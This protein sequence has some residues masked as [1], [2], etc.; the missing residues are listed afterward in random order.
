MDNT[1]LYLLDDKG[2][3]VPPGS[4]G[5]LYVAG[6]NLA[7]GYVKGRDAHR[8]VENGRQHDRGRWPNL[9]SDTR[10]I[11]TPIYSARKNYTRISVFDPPPS[12]LNKKNHYLHIRYLCT[13]C[14]VVFAH[15]DLGMDRMYQTGDYGKMID[16]VL[17]Y[18]GRTDSQVKVRGHRV[19]LSEVEAAVQGLP[20]SGI[21]K[22]TVLCYR[23]GETEQVY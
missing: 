11:F 4:V 22:V 21:D 23:P 16:G 19:D 20:D 9:L 8:F 7:S 15:I 6:A 14:D 1:A 2:Q 10:K 12:P 17:L 3:T 5:E 18:E 13:H